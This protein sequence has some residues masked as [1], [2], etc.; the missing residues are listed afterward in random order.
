MPD[1]PFA[2]AQALLREHLSLL[3]NA[4]SPALRTDVLFV[5]SLP[6]KLWSQEEGTSPVAGSWPLLTFLM[7]R[8]LNANLDP[9]LSARVASGVECLLCALDLLDDVEDEDDTPAIRHLGIPRAVNCSTAFLIV[10]QHAL[11]S[12]QTLGLS[13]G[14]IHTMKVTLEATLLQATAGQHADL[15]AEQVTT[16]DLDACLEMARQKAGSLMRLACAMG[17]LCATKDTDLYDLACAFGENL[18]IAHQLDNDVHDL[19]SLLHEGNTVSSPHSLYHSKKTDLIRGK[20]T[21]PLVMVASLR[22]LQQKPSGTVPLQENY[23]LVETTAL[24]ASWGVYQAYRKQANV[25]LQQIEDRS[26]PAPFLR[27]L[28]GLDG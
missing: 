19:A 18:G 12:L 17:V 8:H 21:T 27:L 9:Q 5:L 2:E 3:L 26:S 25:Y 7:A 23:D 24:V 6:G 20:K 14:S 1:N 16:F 4:L 15:L 22:Q 10:A 11:S 13:Q 28:V